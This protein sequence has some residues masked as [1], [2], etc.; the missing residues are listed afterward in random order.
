MTSPTVRPLTR[1][2]VHDL[3]ARAFGPNTTVVEAEPLIGGGFA[4][5]WSVQ[6]SDGRAVVLK[7]EPPSTAKLLRYEQQL[8]EAEAEYFRLV[9]D[10]APAVPVPEVL[11]M[12]TD[13]AWLF[14]IRLPG[15]AL[16]QL[17]KD[18]DT[19]AVRRDLGRAVAA[20]H[21]VT[22]ERYG[23]AHDRPSGA[24]WTSAFRGI[25][26]ALLADAGDWSVDL[27]DV[28]SRIRTA[29]ERADLTFDGP[30]AL[31]HF[32]LWDGNVLATVQDGEAR[33]SGLVDGERW[34]W[35]D[36]LVDLVS[37]AL[38]RRI[39]DEPDHPFLAGYVA[40]S[41]ADP[42]AQ[43]AA[44]QRLRFYRLHLALVMVVELASRG[45]VGPERADWRAFLWAQLER[46][47]SD[48]ET[49]G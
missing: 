40:A 5:V 31:L 11:A 1:D 20:L 10:Q 43:P 41:G 49:A 8:V 18:V 21:A 15:V 25:I 13:P 47:L 38:F 42:L 35:G 23:Y 26:E 24:T 2:D 14:T 33:L 22:G 29:L 7:V 12:G 3:V 39:E 32:D 19:A 37:P 30:P 44:R 6:L 28:P 17:G 27:A 48:I 36:P 16:S 45:D 9:R 4:A 46:S 34:L